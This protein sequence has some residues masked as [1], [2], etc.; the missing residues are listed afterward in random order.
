MVRQK[1]GNGSTPASTL[2]EEKKKVLADTKSARFRQIPAA[3]SSIR[4]NRQKHRI[5]EKDASFEGKTALANAAPVEYI[6][7]STGSVGEF[8]PN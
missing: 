7:S 2:L 8:A 5:A 3:G 1:A 6:S 4:Y